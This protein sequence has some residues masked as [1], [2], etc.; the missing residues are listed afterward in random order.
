MMKCALHITF[1]TWALGKGYPE[2]ERLSKLNLLPFN[3]VVFFFKC[4]KNMYNI[5]VF[6]FKCFKNMYNLDILDF[7]SFCSCNKPLRN[8]DYLTLDVPFSRTEHFSSGSVAHGMNYLLALGRLTPCQ[9]FARNCL[10]IFTI[11]SVLIF[12]RDK[13]ILL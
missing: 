13:L 4:F 7:V 2:H 1:S 8:V 3:I 10:I 6:F 11:S 5:V 12:Y 9:S